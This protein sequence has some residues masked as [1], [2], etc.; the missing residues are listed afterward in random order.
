[1]TPLLRLPKKLLGVAAEVALASKALA[2]A[3]AEAAIER[4]RGGHNGHSTAPSTMP[5]RAPAARAEPATTPEPAPAPPAPD[6]SPDPPPIAVVPEPTRGQAARIR[7]ARREAETT[8][9]SPGAVIRVD[10][11]WSGYKQMK[12]PE[13]IDRLRVADDA[14]KA[15]V[16]LFE[17]GH[18]KRKTVLEAARA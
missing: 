15:V 14:T 13:I 9:D 4:V 16:L 2:E 18:R 8:E 1:M 17:S 12:A 7:E 5:P 3:V 6:P 11:P 10:E